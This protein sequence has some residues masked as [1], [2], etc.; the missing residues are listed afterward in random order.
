MF[1]RPP[2]SPPLTAADFRRLRSWGFNTVRLGISWKAL[3]PTPG[4]VDRAYLNRVL[5]I[6]KRWRRKGF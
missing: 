2:Y 4:A 1:K 6:T 5:A 3:S